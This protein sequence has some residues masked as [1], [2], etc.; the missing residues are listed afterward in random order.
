MTL[1]VYNIKKLTVKV[2]RI[3]MYY[4]YLPP[5]MI[6]ETTSKSTKRKNIGILGLRADAKIK[7]ISLLSIYTY[8]NEIKTI[9]DTYDYF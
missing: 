7:Y 9:D 8:I 3:I 4:V 5:L 6:I 1:S 2:Y